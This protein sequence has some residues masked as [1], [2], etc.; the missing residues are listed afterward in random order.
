MD[1]IALLVALIAAATVSIR[2][3]RSTHTRALR[4]I[5]V[6]LCL[7]VGHGAEGE[8]ARAARPESDVFKNIR[9]HG[10]SG[11]RARR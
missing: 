6:A 10:R 7:A 1:G 11:R 3:F 9:S 5:A 4:T 2:E 8:Q